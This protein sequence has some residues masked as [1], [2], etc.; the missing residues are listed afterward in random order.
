MCVCG[1]GGGGGGGS[2][3]CHLL[4]ANSQVSFKIGHR[5]PT[6]IVCGVILVYSQYLIRVDHPVHPHSESLCLPLILL[7]PTEHV[8]GQR[9][10]W[11][12]NECTH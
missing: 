8:S 12:D 10:P 2:E 6:A 9:R 4:M 7:Q 3:S 1:G 11:S 5:T